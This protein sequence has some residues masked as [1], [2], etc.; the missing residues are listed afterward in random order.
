MR[1]RLVTV[2][3]LV[4][5]AAVLMWG[6]GPFR[7]AESHAAPVKLSDLVFVGPQVEPFRRRLVREGLMPDTKSKDWK[8]LSKDV[9]LMVLED[10]YY[11]LRARLFVREGVGWQ[12]VGVDGPEDI[13]R[14]VAAR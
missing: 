7:Q 1:R 5:V 6:R 3:A 11:G 4:G 14:I 10:P 9:G 8:Q 12:P 13:A 2:L